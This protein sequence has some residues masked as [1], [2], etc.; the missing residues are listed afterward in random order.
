MK[1]VHVTIAVK[2]MEESLGFYQNIIG[3]PIT[4]RFSPNPDAEIV[5]LAEGE[6]AIELIWNKSRADISIGADISLGFEVA[7]LDDTIE[8]LKKNGIAPGEISQPNPQVKFF[9]VN[10]PNGVRVQFVENVH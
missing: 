3:L 4:R 8:M 9:F 5:F 6:T 1:L 7:S 10:D 2:N